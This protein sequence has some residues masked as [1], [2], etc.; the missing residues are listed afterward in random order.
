MTEAQELESLKA[1]IRRNVRR[2]QQ[3]MRRIQ[4][5]GYVIN[6]DKPSMRGLSI[7]DKTLKAL[8]AIDLASVEE[9]SFE[10]LDY[11]VLGQTKAAA[12]AEKAA[13]KKP[14]G[15]KKDG[16][17]KKPRVHEDQLYA[18]AQKN[19]LNQI[20]EA[21]GGSK[22]TDHVLKE[23]KKIMDRQILL[24]QGDYGKYNKFLQDH[25]QEI[26]EIL[27]EL[28]KYLPSDELIDEMDEA[29]NYQD[30]SNA[31]SNLYR[32]LQYYH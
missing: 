14:K 1:E 9:V 27:D 17:K 5:K 19:I 10:I 4:A 30:D 8:Q 25:G 22:Y 23:V 28:R 24:L 2:I 11:G 15:K 29:L 7:D 26:N 32:V 31:I 18:L 16:K 21:M 12:R 13:R 3:I 20:G 6:M